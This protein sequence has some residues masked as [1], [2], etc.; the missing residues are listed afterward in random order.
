M[1]NP[2]EKRATEYLRD[3]TAFL[4]VVIPE[5][6]NA[7]FSKHAESGALFDRLCMVIGNPGSGKTTIATLVEYKSVYTLVHSPNHT[8]YTPLIK[9]LNKCKITDRSDIKVLAC[10]IPMESEFRE[11][12][13]LPYD[14]D[15]RLGLLKSY[16]QSKAVILWLQSLKSVGG[17]DLE[18]ST[19]KLKPEF[20]S[21]TESIG[22]KTAE[23]ILNHARMLEKEIYTISASLIPPPA[24]ELPKT[25]LNPYQP[26]L[27][28]DKIIAKRELFDEEF[29]PL[30][31][32]DD[33][34][35]LHPEQFSALQNWLAKREIKISRWLMLRLDAQTP[36]NIIEGSISSESQ[37]S[38]SPIKTS[39]EITDIWLHNS[40]NRNSSRTQ[41]R[42]M[43]KSMANKYLGLMPV[44]NNQGLK[45]FQNLLST[46]PH[47]LT[48]SQL[49]EL[50]EKIYNTQVKHSITNEIKEEYQSKIERFSKDR[51]LEESVKLAM[52]LIMLNRY[53]VRTPQ[54]GFFDIDA[55]PKKPINAN[56][57]ISHGARMHLLHDYDKPYYF[58]IDKVCDG[59][60]ENAEQFLQLAG[61]LVNAS[62]KQIIKGN[63]PVLSSKFQHR[64]LLDKA[65][66]VVSDW[67]FPFSE[68]VKLICDYIGEVCIK[69]TLQPN[70]P[71]DA[72]ANAIGI[73]EDEFQ[74]IVV[75]E[76]R[77]ANILK[78]AIGYGAITLKRNHKTKKSE[79]ALLELS[80]PVLITKKLTFARGGFIEKDV[81]FLLEAL[82]E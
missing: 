16:L 69:K 38:S 14:E 81:N 37:N 32:L 12:W 41:F 52:L 39:R 44:F 54:R 13:E 26:F 17:F 80:G 42:T 48:Q 31:I 34:H 30:V 65:H 2:F 23:D 47:L 53:V 46:E 8:D 57:E 29:Q 56:L 70:A 71:L 28:I 58:G 3:E 20:Q 9:A 82:G 1:S 11:F 25:V 75:S 68:E 21:A 7:Y 74:K 77:L 59:A 79:W 40:N 4:S 64:L 78:Y 60:S 27:A 15:I 24:D 49:S 51:N 55:D 19:I 18:T 62:E 35:S 76:H 10:R 36:S 72:G 50:K 66:S 45:S 67:N 73:K 61:Q 22:G 5:P 43:A 33:F 6:L 63:S